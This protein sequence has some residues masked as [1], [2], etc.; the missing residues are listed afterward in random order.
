MNNDAAATGGELSQHNTE[1]GSKYVF[2]F[3]IIICTSVHENTDAR[4]DLH[5]SS[6]GKQFRG[7]QKVPGITELQKQFA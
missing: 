1:M 5:Y 6:S 7:L 2:P 4:T 3:L